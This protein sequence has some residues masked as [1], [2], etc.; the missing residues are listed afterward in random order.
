MQVSNPSLV[1]VSVSVVYIRE[2]TNIEF[3]V[4][5]ITQHGHHRQIT[6]GLGIADMSFSPGAASSS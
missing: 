5:Q 6:G 1:A 3:E 4:S 2:W